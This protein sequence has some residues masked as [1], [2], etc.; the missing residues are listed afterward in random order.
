MK[1][2]IALVTILS[3]SFAQVA[4]VWAFETDQYNLPPAPLADIGDEVTEYTVENIRAAVNKINKEIEERQNCVSEESEHSRKCEV[5]N[6]ERLAYLRSELSVT[7]EVFKRLGSGFV[8]FAKAGSWMDS[9]RFRAQPARYKTSYKRSIYVSLPTNYFTIS[10]TVKLYGTDLG[11][12]KIA[13]F[14][15]Q[16]YTY[17]RIYRRALAKGS[18]DREATGKAISWGR[19]TEN[20]Y[21]GTLVGGVFSNADLAANYVG[22]KFYEGLT[23]PIAVNGSVRPPTL[24]LKEG[25]WAINE[26]E[27]FE[28]D[29]L[30]PFISDHLNE[31]LNPSVLAPGLRSSVRSVVRKQSCAVWAALYPNRTKRDFEKATADLARWNGEAYG[32][33]KSDKFVT[34]ANTCFAA[35]PSDQ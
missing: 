4:A 10:P 32:F 34:I 8:A 29:L 17:Y 5:K 13:H 22:M 24:V 20:T 35:N 1:G 25:M 2:I 18:S 15:Q 30:K 31:A 9:H 19:M 28:H 6:A 12:D 7:R 27:R 14:F 21:Y 16:G 26:T 11:T 3:I 33:K 23:K